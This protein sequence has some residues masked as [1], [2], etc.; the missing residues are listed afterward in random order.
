MTTVGIS[1][2]YPKISF[3]LIEFT[4]TNTMWILNYTRKMNVTLL[5]SLNTQLQTEGNHSF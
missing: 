4:P 1:N 2:F 3:L 5:V